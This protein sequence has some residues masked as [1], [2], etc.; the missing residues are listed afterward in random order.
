MAWHQDLTITVRNRVDAPGFAPWTIKDGVQNVQPP[1]D[2]LERI[3]AIRIHLD[4]ND[5]ENGPLRVIPGSHRSGRLSSERIAGY[6]T[7]NAVTCTV[8]RGGALLM[9]PLLLHASSACFAPSNRRV[10]HLE[11]SD[12]N[13]PAGLDWY[14]TA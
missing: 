7:S 4:D 1:A 5:I 2:I 8:P 11:F 12:A 9:S 14:T 3:L 6:H 13:L 10:V